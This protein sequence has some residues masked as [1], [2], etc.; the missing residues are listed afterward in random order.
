M[1][2]RIRH[3]ND[4][5]RKNNRLLRF[6]L[7]FVLIFRPTNLDLPIRHFLWSSFKLGSFNVRNNLSSVTKRASLIQLSPCSQNS[8]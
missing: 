7:F 5:N 8:N 4:N 3:H 6:I 2:K 1:K